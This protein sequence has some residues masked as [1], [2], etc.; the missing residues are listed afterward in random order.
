M[1]HFSPTR[2]QWVQKFAILLLAVTKSNDKVNR[3]DI[4]TSAIQ[5]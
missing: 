5:A 2:M 4:V 3:L 1:V